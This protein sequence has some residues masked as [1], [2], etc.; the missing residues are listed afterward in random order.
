MKPVKQSELLDGIVALFS[1]ATSDKRT[2]QAASD[3]SA[4]AATS[5]H[6]LLAEDGLVNQKVAVN[7]L[8][9]RGHTVVVANNGQEALDALARESFDVVLMDVQMPTMDGF[10][11]TARIREGE[12]ASGAHTPIIAMTAHAMKGDRER[13]LEAGM[14]G[15]VSKPIR[16]Q[17]LYE[18][19]EGMATPA[20]QVEPEGQDES[21]QSPQLDRE[22]IL[23]QM[24]GNEATLREVV[25]LFGEE[26]P[27]LMQDMQTAITQQKPA[28][29]QRAAHTLKGTL[30]LFGVEAIAGLAYR[31]ETMG[32]D[33]DLGDAQEACL[34]LEQAIQ[35]LVPVL[36]DLVKP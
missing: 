31:L 22:Q 33:D 13:C 19:V 36:N 6:I 20:A 24:G 32:Q 17:K 30:R 12:A 23:K 11:A 10:E 3:A 1:V 29:L 4:R 26:Y 21:E 14:D 25:A 35:G 15:Y 34:G 27:K 2:A 16:A 7:L 5:L 18:A 9:D 28:E 8:N